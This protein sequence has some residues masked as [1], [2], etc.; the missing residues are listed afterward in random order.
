MDFQTFCSMNPFLLSKTTEDLKELL[1]M[2][3]ISIEI[4]CINITAEK[5]FL[6]S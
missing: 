6:N 3:V 2:W 4:H 1:L 5:N